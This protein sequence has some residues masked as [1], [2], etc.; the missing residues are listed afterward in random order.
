MHKVIWNMAVDL[1]ITVLL[2]L[3]FVFFA[4][5]ILPGD[6]AVAALGDMAGPQQIEAFRK[7]LGLDQPLLYQYLSFVLD[8]LRFDFGRSMSNSE[9]ISNILLQN[10]PYTL[11]LTVASMLLGILIGMPAGVLS[12]IY[13]GG[14]LDYG[15]RIF[16][17]LG[18]CIPDFYL[19]A[20]L[21]IAFALKFDWFPIMGGGDGFLDRMYHLVLPAMTLGLVLAAFTSRLT[22]S[23]LLEVLGK[24]YVRTARAKGLG[25]FLVI[26]KHAL[27]N[28]LIP[29]VTGFG[30]YTLSLLSGSISVELIF[31]RPGL[32]SVLVNAIEA[33][34]YTVVQAG[35]VLFS[36]FVVVVNFAMDFL[37][38]VVDPR[39][40]VKA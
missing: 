40:R 35:L 30:I 23:S 6:P 14:S 3:T 33:R 25:E 22:R 31:S 4:L 17:L 28:A 7:Q 16:A 36:F 15:A 10:L 34:D 27:R 13:R 39:I 11:E 8:M 38:A 24:D 26:G 9:P 2:V 12:A 1:V 19:G 20:L 29:V 37:Y 18:F 32:G 21:L 5:R